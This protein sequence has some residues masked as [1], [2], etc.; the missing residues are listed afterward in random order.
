MQLLYLCT[1][2]GYETP[3]HKHTHTRTKRQP[4]PIPSQ[5]TSQ[6]IAPR[7][8]QIN[9]RMRAQTHSHT[10]IATLWG[11]RLS[12]GTTLSALMMRLMALLARCCLLAQCRTHI[13]LARI[14]SRSNIVWCVQE[15]IQYIH[16]Y[17]RVP[18]AFN[19]WFRVCKSFL[20]STTKFMLY[21]IQPQ[22]L[23]YKSHH[24]CI[25]CGRR[26][27]HTRVLHIG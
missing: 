6:V 15:H 4:S 20:C 8:R 16:V 23:E 18:I 12:N 21:V 19:A 5:L 13:A 22:I 9:A 11:M 27:I 7:D 25:L 1:Q 10:N 14:R 3:T 24:R 26:S 17:V 2:T